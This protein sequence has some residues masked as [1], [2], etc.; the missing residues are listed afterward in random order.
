MTAVILFLFLWAIFQI[1][2]CWKIAEKFFFLKSCAVNKNWLFLPFTVGFTHHGSRRLWLI[3]WPVALPPNPLGA[4]SSQ[5]HEQRQMRLVWS[6][7]VGGTNS[8]YISNHR[9]N[10]GFLICMVIIKSLD[11]CQ[12]D[13]PSDCTDA[14]QTLLAMQNELGLVQI[15]WREK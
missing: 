2:L 9:V 11:L 13:F 14:F 15:S 12:S 5:H 10:W 6:K 8:C 7:P 3:S 4:S 1:W